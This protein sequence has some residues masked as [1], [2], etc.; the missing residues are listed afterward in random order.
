MNYDIDIELYKRLCDAENR[1][2]ELKNYSDYFLLYNFSS[3]RKNLYDWFEFDE[4]ASLLEIGSECGCL[5]EFFA[6][7]VKSVTALEIDKTKIEINRYR[8]KKNKN[9][10]VLTYNRFSFE[11]AG[12]FKYIVLT[13]TLEDMSQYSKDGKI[14]DEELL[15]SLKNLLTEDGVIFLATNNKLALSSFAGVAD[16][17]QGKAFTGL[18]GAGNLYTKDRLMKLFMDTGL[19]RLDTYYPMPDYRLPSVLYSDEYLPLPGDYRVDNVSFCADSAKLFDETSVADELL[20]DRLFPEFA[21]SYLFL[22][23]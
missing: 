8:N 7:R 21:N 11:K 3:A 19:S 15:M 14:S 12:K 6:K 2:A 23:R 4:T 9:V 20:K 5:T 18:E 17:V 13:G 22:L 16:P 10:K 1:D